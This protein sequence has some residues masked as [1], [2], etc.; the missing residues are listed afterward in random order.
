MAVVHDIAEGTGIVLNFH[1]KPSI[2]NAVSSPVMSS[3]VSV[4]HD[5]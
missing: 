4:S 3:P 2:V 5:L 1:P